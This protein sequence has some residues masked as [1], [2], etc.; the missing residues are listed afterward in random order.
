MKEYNRPTV[1]TYG[2]VEE[3]TQED[4]DGGYD[5]VNG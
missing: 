2:T 1:E 4:L 3:I 5:S